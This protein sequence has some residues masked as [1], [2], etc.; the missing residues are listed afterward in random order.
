M[1]SKT[2]DLGRLIF[3]LLLAIDIAPAYSQ[4]YPERPI[5]W[6]VPYAP[7][8]SSD[9][10]ARLLSEPL[11]AALGQPIV[12]ENRPGAGSMLGTDAVAKSAPDGYTILLA[13][14]PHTIV[15]AVQAG[16][17]PY[18]PIGDFAPVTLLGVAPLM[19]FVHPGVAAK[20]L[21]E[22]ITAAKQAPERIAIGS[23]GNGS[24]THLMAALL[25]AKTEI[26]LTHIPYK[27]AGPALNDTIAGQIQAMFTT[28]PTAAPHLKAGRLR[29]LA[30]SAPKRLIDHPEVPTFTES[31]LPDLV[32]QHWW[33]VLA[34]AGVPVQTIERLAQAIVQ[35]LGQPDLREKFAAAGVMPPPAMGPEPLRALIGTDLQ[36][37]NKVVRDARISAD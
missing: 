6:V 21:A 37:W 33:G 13:D 27:G 22:F 1:S 11:R 12:V 18:D 5:R 16:K 29:A 19:L 3:G 15:P 35:A 32:V 17:T 8:G 30:V 7:G 4:S 36:R 10:L 2:R 26:R 34:P 14:M 28:L 31:G 24:A 20:T 9:V 23:G 25:Q